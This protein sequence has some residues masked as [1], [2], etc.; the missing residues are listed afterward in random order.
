MHT[1]THTHICGTFKI[2]MVIKLFVKFV[3]SK[4]TEIFSFTY[5]PYTVRL[6]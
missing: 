4:L 5:K 2:L 3:K 6:K 1:H